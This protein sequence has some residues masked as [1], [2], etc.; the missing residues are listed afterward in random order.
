MGPAI[1]GWLSGF[2]V[3]TGPILLLI[4]IEHGPLFASNAAAWALS[5]VLANVCFSIGYSW[6]AVRYPW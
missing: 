6:A 5:A 1:A 4:A 3:V 2:P